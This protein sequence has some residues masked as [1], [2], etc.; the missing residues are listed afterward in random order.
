MLSI[1][2]AALHCRHDGAELSARARH[3][4]QLAAAVFSVPA[5]HVH[6]RD[7]GGSQPL[8]VQNT[9]HARLR[10]QEYLLTACRC[11]AEHSIA[12]AIAMASGSVC[13]P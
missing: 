3:P 7:C 9:V 5:V 1:P 13:R 12:V 10:L 8:Q 2:S 4:V 11:L 6:W